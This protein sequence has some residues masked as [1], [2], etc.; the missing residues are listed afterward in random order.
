MQKG[1][2]TEL[3]NA[4]LENICL[5]KSNSVLTSLIAEHEQ[6]SCKMKQKLLLLAKQQVS[7]I[8][9]QI[10]ATHRRTPISVLSSANQALTIS[11]GFDSDG[12][13]AMYPTK[14]VN[15][16]IGTISNPP[17]LVNSDSNNAGNAVISDA[18]IRLLKTLKVM[19]GKRSQAKET[20]KNPTSSQRKVIVP[21]IVPELSARSSSKTKCRRNIKRKVKKVKNKFSNARPTKSKHQKIEP[22]NLVT[23]K[24][25]CP[26]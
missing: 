24:P 17:A 11:R 1:Q 15:P 4:R 18:D 22:L 5:R 14:S 12:A 21:S 25:W 19:L 26:V 13:Y 10:Q 8:P 3:E 20:S 16:S 23:R 7:R 2:D 9:C 6:T